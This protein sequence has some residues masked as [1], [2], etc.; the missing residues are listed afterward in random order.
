MILIVNSYI[1][2][3]IDCFP[4]RYRNLRY[5]VR[6]GLVPPIRDQIPVAG[7]RQFRGV[8]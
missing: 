5:P 8:Y 7:Q 2:S 6:V 1:D 3:K 4:G